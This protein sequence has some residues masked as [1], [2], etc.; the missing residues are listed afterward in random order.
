MTSTGGLSFTAAE[1]M[2]DRVHRDAAIV[3]HLA[4]V[5]RAACFADRDILVLEV[6][7][8]ADRG[9]AAHVNLAHLARREPQRRPLALA[10]HELRRR[11]RRTRHLSALAF[12]QLDVVDRRA[13]R[14]AQERKRIADEDVGLG[15]GH[16]RLTDLQ[17]VRS[18]DVALLAVRVRQQRDARGAVRVVLDRLD[19]RRDVVLLPLEVD[20]AVPLLVTAADE[21]RGDAAGRIATARLRLA[22]R[23]RLLRLLLRQSTEIR[24]RLKSDSR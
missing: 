14:H 10:G 18:E 22:L 6:S 15:A 11:S 13:E 2:I 8:T 16:Q 7:D 3:R 12:L 1:R 24:M 17:A 21:A 4:E 5:T 19:L 20:L 9:V 23:E